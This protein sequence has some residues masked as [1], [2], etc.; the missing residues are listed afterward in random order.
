VKAIAIANNPT[1]AAAVNVLELADFVGMVLLSPVID[2]FP[3]PHGHF[4]AGIGFAL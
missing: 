4:A 2:L 3:H 1:I